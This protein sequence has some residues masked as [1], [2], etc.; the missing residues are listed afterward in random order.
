[1]PT[2]FN[3]TDPSDSGNPAG[4]NR[5]GE[6]PIE[7]DDALWELLSVYADGEATSEETERVEALLRSDPAYAREFDF[8]RLTSVSARSYVE[9]DPPAALR[10][11]IFAAT[12]RKQTFATRMALAWENFRRSL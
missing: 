4:K 2:I 7:N 5:A 6:T 8:L 12:I 3:S 9:V 11:A 10:D 1:M